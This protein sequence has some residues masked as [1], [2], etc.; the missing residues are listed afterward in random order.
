[1]ELIVDDID[2]NDIKDIIKEEAH[3]KSSKT[4][5]TEIAVPKHPDTYLLREFTDD[6]RTALLHKATDEGLSLQKFIR[7][8]L[9]DK[10]S[11]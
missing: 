8:T 11:K 7:K 1:M 2:I 9:W 10:V 6:L 5:K 4:Q 3:M